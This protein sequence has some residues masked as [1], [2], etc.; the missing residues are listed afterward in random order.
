M[1]RII[2]QR[3]IDDSSNLSNSS[4]LS[5]LRKGNR[6]K[7]RGFLY[8]MGMISVGVAAF[9]RKLTIPGLKKFARGTSSIKVKPNPDAVRRRDG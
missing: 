7:R 1:A 4:D 6:M 3:A 9:S 2:V 5:D 8:Y